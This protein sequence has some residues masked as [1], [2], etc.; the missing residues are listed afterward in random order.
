MITLS[1]QRNIEIEEVV[2]LYQANAW[3]SANHPTTLYQA[4]LNSHSL[5]TAREEN[6]LIGLGNAISDGHL[7]VYYP[8]LLVH[9]HYQGQG[10]GR[11][12][13][14]KMQHKYRHFH[15]QI[16]TADG[17]STAFYQKLGFT[18]AGQTQPMWIYQGQEH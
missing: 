9:P 6:R 11:M 17:A 5:V 2:K 16:L 4:L 7:V 1:D 15:M 18:K 14:E 13:M 10:V 12:I 3:S 8:H